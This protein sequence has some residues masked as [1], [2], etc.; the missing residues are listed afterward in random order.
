MATHGPLLPDASRQRLAEDTVSSWE[1]EKENCLVNFSKMHSTTVENK[2]VEI[3][4]ISQRIDSQGQIISEADRGE[5]MCNG[6]AKSSIEDEVSFE[7]KAHKEIEEIS[8]RESDAF[9]GEERSINA[10]GTPACSLVLSISTGSECSTVQET[11][12][13]IPNEKEERI[14]NVNNVSTVISEQSSADTIGTY[15]NCDTPPKNNPDTV[16]INLKSRLVQMVGT[17]PENQ[18]SKC[19][20][21]VQ[22]PRAIVANSSATNKAAFRPLAWDLYDIGFSLV[23]ERVCRD[24]INWQVSGD[25][26][27]ADAARRQLCLLT[28][29]ESKLFT[30]NKV[31]RKPTKLCRCG[32]Q[33]ESAVVI[34]YHSQF[35]GVSNN[36]DS[37]KSCCLCMFSTG[38]VRSF[39][40][41]LKRRHKV[42]A[43]MPSKAAQYQCPFC[44]CE[45]RYKQ[46]LDRHVPGCGRRFRLNDNLGPCRTH[47]DLPIYAN[48]KMHMPGPQATGPA[49]VPKRPGISLISPSA[50]FTL[51]LTRFLMPSSVNPALQQLPRFHTTLQS[52]AGSYQSCILVSSLAPSL[53]P[54]GTAVRFVVPQNNLQ[55]SITVP[56]SQ[57]SFVVTSNLVQNFPHLNL[58][59]VMNGGFPNLPMVKSAS[60]NHLLPNTIVSLP[61]PVASFPSYFSSNA[62]MP[63]LLL[64][65]SQSE[66]GQRQVGIHNFAQQPSRSV[67]TPVIF[68]SPALSVMSPFAVKPHFQAGSSGNFAGTI[69]PFP[70]ST[71]NCGSKVT[72]VGAPQAKVKPVITVSVPRNLNTP[73]KLI[74]ENSRRSLQFYKS[75]C[76]RYI[77]SKASELVICEICDGFVKDRQS[78]LVHFQVVHQINLIDTVNLMPRHSCA[79]CCHLFF[80]MS[81]VLRHFAK[82]HS[83]YDGRVSKFLAKCSLCGDVNLDNLVVHL[84]TRHRAVLILSRDFTYCGICFLSIGD[85]QMF[86]R[87]MLT[88]HSEIFLSRGILLASIAAAVNCNIGASGSTAVTK[89]KTS[90]VETGSHH[91]HG[92]L[93]QSSGLK[94][95]RDVKCTRCK[96][97]FKTAVSLQRH[98][99]ASHSGETESCPLCL[100]PVQIGLPFISHMTSMHL[101]RCSVRVKRILSTNLTNVKEVTKAVLI[102]NSTSKKQ[103]L[104]D[105]CRRRCVVR[106]TRLNEKKLGIKSKS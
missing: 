77:S 74:D 104:V 97:T 88:V 25:V 8:S 56:S 62:S 41:H 92:T 6:E 35:G 96:L 61:L 1:T 67:Y 105:E 18:N 75:N 63:T 15:Q 16:V 66:N 69:S 23:S 13:S 51:P 29:Y 100:R 70:N 27:V 59:P 44:P 40:R 12:N 10:A 5:K 24:L 90:S 38:N 94:C 42:K 47:C 57:A 32:F 80:T 106:I 65:C 48:D 9:V 60:S 46:Q 50:D 26:S 81:G 28:T 14:Y 73:A 19:I 49:L 91:N 58:P 84:S 95:D 37:F 11:R 76:P 93:K 20:V 36:D 7:E 30:K 83:C 72:Y 2:D 102:S 21:I 101:K 86:E 54:S 82:K 39:S 99:R 64:P 33:S 4:A 3:G 45:Y 85:V 79:F 98:S 43:M 34:A 71:A 89:N 78:L 87:H 103:I 52:E 55:S 68:P 22:K 31:I 17:D 53:P